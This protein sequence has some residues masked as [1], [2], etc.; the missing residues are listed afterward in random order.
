[1]II[2]QELI[3]HAFEQYADDALR[4]AYA[5][6]CRENAEDIVQTVFLSLMANCPNIENERHLKAWILRVTMNLCHNYHKSWHNKK[7][8]EIED[9]EAQMPSAP[10]PEEQTELQQT[11]AKLPEKYASVLFLHYYEGYST[12]EIGLILGKNEN[13]VCSLLRRG[14]EKLK[15]E[16]QE[17]GFAYEY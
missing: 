2:D 1:M 13:T 12:R 9:M 15:L 5:C 3:I 14:R 7:R 8:T 16:L 6:G 11:I 4:A 10:S 17:G